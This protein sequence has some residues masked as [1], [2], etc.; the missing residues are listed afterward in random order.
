MGDI[1][2]MDILC[3]LSMSTVTKKFFVFLWFWYTV[4]LFLTSLTVIYRLLVIASPMFR[5]VVFYLKSNT[6]NDD[7]VIEICDNCEVK[8]PNQ[9]KIDIFYGFLNSSYTARD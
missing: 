2:H 3:V 9:V 7:D 6:Q 4:L 8:W 1:I 5:K